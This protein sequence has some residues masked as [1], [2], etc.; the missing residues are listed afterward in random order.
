MILTVKIFRADGGEDEEVGT[1][2]WDED[3]DFS[4]SPVDSS[5]LARI[6]E[7]PIFLKGGADDLHATD[8]PYTFMTNLYKHYK[9]PYLRATEAEES[10]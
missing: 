10:D 9:S 2:Q 3:G 8:D 5:L 4:I 6:M 7:S 1:I